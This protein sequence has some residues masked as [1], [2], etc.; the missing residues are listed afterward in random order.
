MTDEE[1]DRKESFLTWLS[2]HVAV[3]W[4]PK[5]KET[6]KQSLGVIN[7]EMINDNEF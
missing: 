2:I 7:S 4:I 1:D 5:M 3:S 6:K